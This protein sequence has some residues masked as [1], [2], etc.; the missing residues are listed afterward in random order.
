[1]TQC[2]GCGPE[3][4]GER[5]GGRLYSIVSH[6]GTIRPIELTQRTKNKGKR[7]SERSLRCEHARNRQLGGTLSDHKASESDRE[8]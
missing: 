7:G 3:P 4:A 2:K 6:V 5:E 8:S 1:M